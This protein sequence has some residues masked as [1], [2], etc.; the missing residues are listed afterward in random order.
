MKC[1]HLSVFG[2]NVNKATASKRSSEESAIFKIKV[3]L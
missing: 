2:A 1:T 3:A